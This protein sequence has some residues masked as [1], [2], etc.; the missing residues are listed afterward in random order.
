[1]SF[2]RDIVRWN[3]NALIF[4]T[5]HFLKRNWGRFWTVLDFIEHYSW[6]AWVALKHG[7]IHTAHGFKALF[8]DGKWAVKTQ[9]TK[10]QARYGLETYK[11]Q[12]KL[13]QVQKDFI[14]F[15]P[16]SFF[17]LIP[18]G[19]IFLPAWVLIFPNSI[20]SQFVADEEREKKFL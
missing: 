3:E 20:P 13:A 19:E 11:K 8:K 5:S 16:F 12:K 18:G 10:F 9:S 1:M 2:I 6:V 17:I 7:V 15:I 4:R 14:K